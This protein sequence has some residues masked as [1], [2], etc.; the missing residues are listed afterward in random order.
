[1]HDTSFASDSTSVRSESP[2]TAVSGDVRAM[3]TVCEGLGRPVCEG[4]V[5]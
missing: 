3:H 1:M 2:P 4:L 5:R